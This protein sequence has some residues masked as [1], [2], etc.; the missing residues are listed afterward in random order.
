MIYDEQTLRK[1][2]ADMMAH[3]E[4]EVVEFK[5]AKSNYNLNISKL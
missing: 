5:E 2:L 3:H 4:N 1:K